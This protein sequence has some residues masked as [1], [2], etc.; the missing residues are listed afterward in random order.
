VPPEKVLES[1]G[2]V[3]HL[4][5]EGSEEAHNRILNLDELINLCRENSEQGYTLQEFFDHAALRSE[6][7]DFDE[8]AAVS[9][10]TLHNAKGLE[11]PVV[12]LVGWEEGLFPHSRSVAEDD[13]EEER[14]LC[15][16]GLTRAQ[17]T[18]YLTYSLRRRFFGRESEEMNRPS[19]FIQEIPEHL[20]KLKTFSPP[21]ETHSWDNPKTHR[22]RKKSAAKLPIRTY[23][24]AKSV[25]GFL[26]ELPHKKVASSGGLVSGARIVHDKFGYG[27]VLRV[28]NTGDDLTV[29]V[30]FPGLG[31]KK[32]LQSYAKLKL[33]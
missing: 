6:V 13:L 16:V 11:F 9:L 18:I 27:T 26:D 29:T 10:M 1:S 12:F 22:F 17:K 21:P 15:Y 2:Y 28:Q 3:A 32:L 25:R 5:D 20:L 19:R 24:S 23:N 4:K 8:S 31:I 30:Q 33:V 7:D 14:R